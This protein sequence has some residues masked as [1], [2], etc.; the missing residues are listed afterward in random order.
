MAEVMKNFTES[1]DKRI[2]SL[3]DKIGNRDHSDMRGQIYSII[4]SPTFDLYTIRQR[5][6]AKK[7]FGF[8]FDK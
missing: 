7:G 2:G 4:E 5:I 6:R 1:Q 3:I 8:S